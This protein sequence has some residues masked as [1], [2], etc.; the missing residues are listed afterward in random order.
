MSASRRFLPLQSV[1]RAALLTVALLSTGVI[2]KGPRSPEVRQP[3]RSARSERPIPVLAPAAAGTSVDGGAGAGQAGPLG[4]SAKVTPEKAQLGEP[5][6]VLLEVRHVKGERYELRTPEKLGPFELLGQTR[7]REDASESATTRFTL[8]LSAFEL[9]T[10]QLPELTFDVF[11]VEGLAEGQSALWRSSPG[12]VEIVS[13]L[14]AEAEEKGADLYDI[15][16]LEEVPIRSYR[17][18]YAVLALVAAVGLGWLL[19]RWWKRRKPAEVPAP[20]PLP[21]AER[22]LAALSAL[23]ARHLPEQGRPREFYFELSEIL[24]GYLGERYG[25]DALESTSSELVQKLKRLAPP[26]LP[27]ADLERFSFESDLAKFAREE[28]TVEECAASLELA[29]RVVQQTRPAAPP[30]A[31]AAGAEPLPGT[32]PGPSKKRGG[33]GAG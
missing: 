27:V 12:T 31:E 18:L 21:L 11:G 24:R 6:D 33:G 4:S 20:A 25:I 32:Q 1:G 28:R 13:S 9:G 30:V 7:T 26:G 3:A 19:Y 2:A 23:G 8:R 16:P 5:F 10:L 15:R 29:F 14:P 22:T 17:I